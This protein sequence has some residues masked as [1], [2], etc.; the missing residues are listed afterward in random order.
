M[1]LF[2]DPKMSIYI[3]IRLEDLDGSHSKWKSPKLASEMVYQLDL[4]RLYLV[5]YEPMRIDSPKLDGQTLIELDF[6]KEWMAAIGRINQ[7]WTAKFWSSWI[8]T[9]NE[10]LKLDESTEIGLESAKFG[11]FRVHENW[12]IKIGQPNSDRVGFQQEMNG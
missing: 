11:P 12:L 8:S 2:S 4:H 1:F 3:R 5:D 7:N 10:W 9:R 6:N